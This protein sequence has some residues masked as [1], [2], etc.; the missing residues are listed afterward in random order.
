MVVVEHYFFFRLYIQSQVKVFGYVVY[1]QINLKLGIIFTNVF[2]KF[3]FMIKV[4]F[5]GFKIKFT[6]SV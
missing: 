2:V 6:C 5:G 4:V 3:G 1:G